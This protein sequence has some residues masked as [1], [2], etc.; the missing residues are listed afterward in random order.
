MNHSTALPNK[1][2]LCYVRP[3]RYKKPHD[4]RIRG[5]VENHSTRGLLGII[6]LFP[7]PVGNATK[8]SLPASITLRIADSCSSLNFP[9]GMPSL[10]AAYDKLSRR[11]SSS[12]E[13]PAILD[14]ENDVM[15]RD[16]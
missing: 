7:K 6:A 3:I 1:V 14:E 12:H 16:L 10:L 2:H 5:R 4:H 9:L 13:L 15:S 8:I 11:R